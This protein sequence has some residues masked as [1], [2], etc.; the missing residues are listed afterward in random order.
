MSQTKSKEIEDKK[1]LIL[2][3]DINGTITDHDSTE[4]GTPGQLSN[5]AL[6]RHTYGMVVNNK[7]ILNEDLCGSANSITYYNYVKLNYPNN[8]KEKAFIFTEAKEPG[9]NIRSYLERVIKARETLLFPSFIE[10]LKKYKDAKI[11][12]RTFGND[13]RIITDE[14]MKLDYKKSFVNGTIHHN[15]KGN[16]S[17]ILDD[18]KEYEGLLEIQNFIVSS[19]DNI[20]IKEDYEYWNKNKKSKTHGKLLVIDTR[21]NRIAFDDN[22]CFSCVDLNCSIVQDANI[23]FKVNTIQA[24]LLSW[25]YTN[26]IDAVNGWDVNKN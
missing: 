19:K 8:Y 22:N 18:K 5:M 12:L 16:V 7:W 25:Y 11:I 10:V 24:M 15:S 1:P 4:T 3:F 2:D 9:H 26:I 21:V 6:S 14:L 13:A 17:L 23:F 20:V